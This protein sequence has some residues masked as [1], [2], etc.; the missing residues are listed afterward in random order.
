MASWKPRAK[1][2]TTQAEPRVP[3]L[4]LHWLSETWYVFSMVL[5]KRCRQV[6]EHA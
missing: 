3:P 1:K 4:E 5:G 6:R 2:L